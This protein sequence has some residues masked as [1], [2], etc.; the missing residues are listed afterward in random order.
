[1]R[2]VLVAGARPNFMK[3]AP[4]L[5]ECRRRRGGLAAELVHTGQ[6]YDAEMS[7]A[8]FAQ[9][10][11]PAPDHFLSAGSG[12]HAV[13]TARIM[14]AFE[15]VLERRAPDVV[16]V[17][18]DVNS[19]LACSLTACKL[20]IRVAHVEAG[21]R[22]RDAAMPE[23]INRV[24]T[25]AVSDY[26]FATERSAVENLTAEGK[27]RGSIH[28]VGNVMIDTLRHC[29]TRLGGEAEGRPPEGPYAV[30]TLH[31][32]SNVDDRARLEGILGALVRIASDMPLYF[33]LHPRTRKSIETH[34]LED[35]LSAPGMRA[36]PPMG[37]LDFLRVWKDARLV[38]TDSGGLQEETTALGVPCLT[39]RENTERPIT[40]EEGTNVLAGTTQEGILRCYDDF[41]AGANK[42]GRIPELWDGRAAE[43]IVDIL[44]SR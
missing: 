4:I 16:V 12:S 10:E 11:I 35:F 39:I 21:L 30:V 25:D 42:T 40:I 6:H 31:R 41:R 28:L 13:Q 44:L 20:G 8:F 3:V 1:M 27:A 19:T 36:L 38:L 17:V 37:Y 9:L 18:G 7:E 14:I 23:E 24:V 32:P 2:A 5:R 29:L 22:S 15:E 33:P 43:R 34:G 26:L